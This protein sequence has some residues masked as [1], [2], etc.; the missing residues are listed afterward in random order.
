MTTPDPIVDRLQQQ[1][2]DA[3][4]SKRRLAPRGAGSKSWLDA[5]ARAGAEVLDLAACRGIVSYEPTELVVTARA[6]TPLV[7]LEA[8]LAAQGQYLAF[9]PPR[10]R[11]GETSATVGGMVAAGLSGPGRLGAGAVRDHVLG[12]SLINGRGEL[13]HFG[14]QVMKNVAGFDVSRLLAGSMG[15]LGAIVDVSL[16]VLPLPVAEATLAFELDAAAAIE[17]VNAWC[18]RPLPISASAHDPAT[19]VLHLRLRGAR[20]AVAAACERLGGERVDTEAAAALWDGLREQSLPWFASTWPG[21]DGT[22]GETLWRVVVPPTT[23]PLDLPGSQLVEWGGA[24]R[25]LRT[26]AAAAVVRDAAI[27]A[28]GHA[29]CLR[30][31]ADGLPAF[32]PPAGALARIAQQLKA[33][34]DPEGV[35][36]SCFGSL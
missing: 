4:A 12:T 17:Q 31:G 22:P 5:G 34:F 9:E 2:R 14:G 10:L 15:S 11:A 25:W 24:Q 33:S 23:P 3:A 13:L 18:A 7:E 35:F 20:A 8:E 6:G 28:G 16:K 19:R 1:V 29:T 26:A 32:T 36:P 21:S 30:G 27:A